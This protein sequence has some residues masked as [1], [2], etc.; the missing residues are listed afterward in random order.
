MRADLIYGSGTLSLELPG[1]AP[2]VVRLARRALDAAIDA[3]PPGPRLEGPFV[4]V[5]HDPPAVYGCVRG[6]TAPAQA[7]AAAVLRRAGYVV[8]R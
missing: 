1:S 6:C 4:E 3:S 5:V 8:A 2:A 7:A